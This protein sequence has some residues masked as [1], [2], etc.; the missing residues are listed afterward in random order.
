ME[1]IKEEDLILEIVAL[2]QRNRLLQHDFDETMDVI[3]SQGAKYLHERR[4]ANSI[5]LESNKWRQRYYRLLS[6]G[7]ILAA[8]IIGAA[9]M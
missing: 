9:I 4:R 5:T 7:L 6:I 1:K 8:A 2:N 3:S